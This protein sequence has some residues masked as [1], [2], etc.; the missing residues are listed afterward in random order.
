MVAIFTG[1][2]T[3][4]ERGS[5]SVLGGSGLL[6]SA[7][8]GRGGEQLF[9][10]AASGNLVIRHRD[11]FL[12]GRGG[13]VDVTRTYNSLG[14]LS[15]ENG[16]NWRQSTDRRIF[17]FTGTL[18]AWGSSVKRRSADGSEISYSWNGSAYVTTDGSGAFDTL[19]HDAG[20]NWTWTDGSSRAVEVYGFDNG[21][22]R[23]V[24]ERDTSGNTI[25][26]SYT[27]DHLT[28][29]AT[30]NGESIEYSWSGNNITGMVTSYIDLPSNTARTLTRTRYAYDGYGR[31]AT[32]TVDLTPE[33]NSVGNGEV[34]TT[35]YTYHGT[36][37]LVASISETDGSR[38]DIGYDGALRVTSITQAVASGVS[39]ITSFGYYDG[40]TTITDPAGQVT[41]L[42]FVKGDT[43]LE[44]DAWPSGNVVKEPATID[45]RAAVKYT[46]SS[47]GAWSGVVQGLAAAAGE[48]ISFALTLQASGSI[49]TQDLGLYGD[50]DQWGQNDVSFARIVS[51]PGQIQQMTGGL[52]RIS[53]LSLTQGTRIEITRTFKQ[54]QSG[55][56]Y[57]YV[58]NP[59]GY[60][61]G[62]SL[63]A[64]DP[65]LL[66]ST[67]ATSAAQMNLANWG[68]YGGA[69]RQSVG[70]IDGSPAYQISNPQGGWSG[71]TTSLTASAGDSYSF[72]LSLK[73]SGGYASQSIGLWGDG[74]HWGGND[75][76]SARIVS[77]PGTITQVAGGLFTVSG[78]SDTQVTRIEIVR[79][80]TQTENGGAYIYID[81]PGNYRAG[82]S[83]IAA[84]PLLTKRLVEPATAGQLLKITA[85][86]AQSGAAQQMVQF[87][88]DSQGNLVSVTDAAGQSTSYVYD[89]S[90]NV[91]TE[92]DRLGNIVTRTY[93]AANQILT[94][95]RTGSDKDLDAAA[96]TTHY[97]YDGSN[98]LVYVVSPEGRVTRNWYDSVG[99]LYWICD[100]PDYL[101]DLN[102]MVAGQSPSQAQLDAW[103]TSLPES[104][105]AEIT[106]IVYDARGNVSRQLR[107]SQ[108]YGY[109]HL[110]LEGDY[111]DQRFT[112]DAGGQLISRYVVG[113][114]TES[115][116]YDGLGRVVASTDL[117]GGTTNVVFADAA[118]Q[119]MVRL[120][121]G[122]VQT[123]TYNKAGELI[124]FTEAGANT[125]VG[126]AQY[127]YDRNGHLRRMIDASGVRSYFLYDKVGRKIAD[128]NEAGWITE[129]RYD[130]ND[131]LVATARY[132]NG[133]VSPAALFTYLVDPNSDI[134]LAAYRPV[135]HSFDI[136]TWTVY[137]KDGRAIEAINGDGSVAAY[138]YD[139]SGRLVR[140]VRYANKLSAAQVE[141]FKTVAPA[142]LLLPGADARDS[143]SRN[144]Y[145]KDGNLIG[146]LDGEGYLSRIVYD[147]AG[148]KVQELTWASPTN[149]ALR[150]NG[151]FQALIGSVGSD[152]RT[153]R[154]VYDGQGLLRFQIDSLFQV[155]EFG[156]GSGANAHGLVRQTIH[157]AASIPALSGYTY[158]AVKNAVASFAGNADNRLS[159]AVYDT[160]GRLA[161]SI[162]AAGGVIGYGYD[163]RGQV[164]RET[165]YANLRWT[166]SL[167]DKAAM[168]AWAAAYPSADDRTT[169]YFYN[170]RGEL[171][172]TVDADGYAT[173]ADYDAE[174]RKTWEGRWN[175]RVPV[176]DNLTFQ[177][178]K[179]L[180]DGWTDYTSRAWYYDPTGRL[181][182]E[183]NGEGERRDYVYWATGELARETVGVGTPDASHTLYVYDAAGHV[184]ARYDGYEGD[185][186]YALTTFTYDG[187]GNLVSTIDAN[188]HTTSWTW[189]RLGRKLSQT[190][191]AGG[192]ASFEYNAFGDLVRSTDARG[193]ATWNYYDRL[194]R[195]VI[196]RDAEDY[197]TETGYTVFGEVASV[198]RRASRATNAAGVGTWPVFAA[199]GA[200]AVT[201]FGYD[202]LG[203]VTTTT[204]AEGSV[205]TTW[206]DAFG[207]V[208]QARNKLGGVTVFR[209][210]RRGLVYY[211]WAVGEA[212]YDGAGN[213]VASGFYKN[214]YEYDARGNVVHQIEAYNLAERRDTW[215]SYD[216]AGRLIE[217]RGTAVGVID[218]S[219]HIGLGSTDL[220]ARYRY[221][222]RGNLI[223]TSDANGARTLFWYDELDRKVAELSPVGTLSTYGYDGVG[224]LTVSRTYGTQIALPASPGGAPPA[225]PG[226]EYRETGY[227]YDA[228]NR[229]T[230][231]SVA[232]I[233]TGAWNGTSFVLST[234]AITASYGYDAAGNVVSTTDANGVT[235]YAYYDRLGRKTA[236]VE[237]AGY[238][239][240][241]TLDS[242]G[243]VLLER[244]Y[245]T[246]T[247]GATASVQPTMQPADYD[248]ITGF[249]Y[250][251]MGR[252][253]AEHRYSVEAYAV[254]ASN[255]V[256]TGN[257]GASSVYY[258]YNGLGQVT[259]KTE[260]TGEY[261]SYG[262]DAFGRMAW[263]QR[264][265]VTDYT[266]ATGS[267][268]VGY[269][270][271]GLGNLVRSNQSSGGN[272]PD[273]VTTYYYGARGRLFSTI[274]AGGAL[275][276]FYYDAAGNV[277]R[278][279]YVRTRSDGS[280]AY[281]GILTT[282]D[283]LGRVTSQTVAVLSGS[284]WVKG[285]VQNVAYNAFGEVAQKGL[286]GGWQEQFAYDGAGRLYRS[287]S[288]DGVWRYYIHDAAGNQSA[289][290]ESEGNAIAGLSLDQ[291]LSSAT[292]GFAY[293]LGQLT[294]DGLN[295]TITGYDQRGQATSTR[296]ARR[297][298][299]GSGGIVDLVTSRSYNAFGEVITETDARGYQTSY[300]YNAMGRT[301]YVTRTPVLITRED[302]SQFL[303][304][305]TEHFYY[306]RSGRLVAHDDAN[307]NRTTRTLLAGTGYGDS[308]ALV[309]WEWHAD[310]GIVKNGYDRF[311]DLR[312]T[313]DEINRTTSMAYDAM[314]RLTQVIR[315]GGL[316][317]YYAYD[318]LGQRIRHWNSFYGTANVERT[319]YDAQGRVVSTRA[320]GGDTTTISYSWSS[321]LA[322]SGMGT[323]GGWVETTT[324]ANGLSGT[325]Y[326][327]MFGRVT[328]KSDLGG[329]TT[330]TTYDLAG[331]MTGR[332][333]S[334]AQGTEAAS[335]V[336][337]NNGQVGTL[338]TAAGGITT[339]QSSGYDA[340]GNK[341]TE[342]TTRNGA[343]IQNATATYD[344]LN[345]LL[346][347]SE[348]G[349]TTLPA[350]SMTYSY[351]A[352][353]NIR[354]MQ[355]SF[356]YLDSQGAVYNFTATQD[357][358]Y[359]Y[360]SMNRMVTSQ[361]ALSGG[362][363][364]GGTQIT[365]DAAG[366]RVSVATLSNGLVWTGWKGTYKT[367]PN[368]IVFSD[369]PGDLQE[370]GYVWTSNGRSTYSGTAVES[371]TY[372]LDGQLDTVSVA[373]E[374]VTVDWGQFNL[375]GV[376]G[377][378]VLRANF[379]YDG[380]G[381]L[382]SQ[383]DYEN[384][385][386]VA[387][388]RSNIVYDDAG[389]VTS[390]TVAA[391]QALTAVS[392][393]FTTTTTYTTYGYG[394][395]TGTGYA[396][397]AVVT[398]DADTWQGGSDSAVPDTRTTYGYSWY[399][400][401]VQSSILYRPDMASSTTNS[402]SFTL[403]P[404]GQVSGASIADGRSR[405]VTFTLD[406][407]GQAV[408]RDEADNLA[409][410][411]PHQL[412]Y[413]F[414][415]RQMGT[416]G[417]DTLEDGDYAGSIAARQIKQGTGPFRNGQDYGGGF[418]RFGEA[419]VP[420]T[421]YAQ[422]AG[423]GSY[424]AEGGETLSQ[425]A[426]QMWGDASLWYLLAEAN[427][428]GGDASLVQGQ[429]ITIPTGVTRNSNTAT[430]FKP[431]DPAETLG[432]LNP[433]T[434]KPQARKNKC[435]TFGAIVL[436]AVAIGLSAWLGPQ[437][438]QA[439]Q[440]LLAGS[441]SALAGS[442]AAI[443]GGVLGGAATGVVSS[444]ASQGFGLATGL[445][446]GGFNWGA[447]AMAGIAGGI[448]GGF[449]GLSQG[450]N[451]AG[452]V[453][454]S[455]KQL[456]GI[457]GFLSRGG[458]TSGA[459]R[460]IVSSAVT[461]G[462]GVA[463]R[464]QS[465]F[466]F[467]GIAAAGTGGGLSAVVGGSGFGGKMLNASA[468]G[469]ASAATRSALTGT[470]FGDNI[471]AV[472][473]DVIG[474]TIGSLVAERV[475]R[476][477]ETSFE[478]RRREGWGPELAQNV[479]DPNVRSDVP[480][481]LTFAP[482]DDGK[483]HK[484]TVAY[485]GDSITVTGQR[486]RGF[487]D[488][489][490][491]WIGT[492]LG[493]HNPHNPS[494]RERAYEA[495]LVI[496][497]SAGPKYAN[498]DPGSYFFAPD[499]PVTGRFTLQSRMF[500]LRVGDKVG[501]LFNSNF[502]AGSA[503]DRYVVT[504]GSRALSTT[505]KH[506]F[507]PGTPYD[508]GIVKPFYGALELIAKTP[509]G[510]PGTIATLESN[511][512]TR[513]VGAF[514]TGVRELVALRGA[515]TA[516][517]GTANP[518]A[519]VLEYGPRGEEIAYRTMSEA[520][521][522]HLQQ[523]GTLL[524]TTET[525]T[526]PL[527]SYAAKYEG[528]TVRMTTA[529]GTSGRLQEVGIAA[530]RPAAA[531]FP[532]MSTQTG[533]WM[534]TNARFKVEGGQMTTQLGQGSALN[535]FNQGLIGFQRVPK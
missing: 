474:A 370:D 382:T 169:R 99:Q 276:E 451:A 16:D 1:S 513:P 375:T 338:T 388:S 505:Y 10:N 498:D 368:I 184:I 164:I 198:T 423:G 398:I 116:V 437:F 167:P 35:S 396:L 4:L 336:W 173:R 515:V 12:T 216:K 2:G 160:A 521:F 392:N 412:W 137:D 33:D 251:R 176:D 144:F 410:G 19:V 334:G 310:G 226:G 268:V 482:N 427:G 345:R 132:A 350:A 28:R 480:S 271:D 360:D 128:I 178:V 450:V 223:E 419:Y 85:P 265:A 456:G 365:Y 95:T 428:M 290:I 414:N 346:T 297:E 488:L 197:I 239:T 489:I 448:G 207:D 495:N 469:L 47:G 504:P 445:Q 458:F 277:V 357:Y 393:S 256:L 376:M 288:G 58:D 294:V 24:S 79:N 248:R 312:T 220:I 86:A 59:G 267:P 238:A 51:G 511:G 341:L 224:N 93:N 403:T 496:R 514:A 520:H 187:L 330:S 383:T 37:K 14:N 60:R 266:G 275:T 374:G 326:S 96:H 523:T 478:R 15:D 97:V 25:T 430:T 379:D 74:S 43:A 258:L 202:K 351:D 100:F 397:G 98:R 124:A 391:R 48:T 23:I 172:Y 281:E 526:S 3:G 324:Y 409:L 89:A 465:K 52:W 418:A 385:T 195:V 285:D 112:Y 149:I 157:Y 416:V 120:V 199:S 88:Y 135:A 29:I 181:T 484:A 259:R 472:L 141:S 151:S 200:D 364:S 399:D 203:R 371:Y 426:A 182:A 264:A 421:S 211:E 279:N 56:A 452:E 231:T 339:V 387:Y 115:F 425:L 461:Q 17:D 335:Y 219:N 174:G 405:S 189:D 18:N 186:E 119:T 228:I 193:N 196:T 316:V 208:V 355:S 243:N 162:D 443:G 150:A 525:S 106:Q 91:I 481:G 9:L 308:E 317:E 121:N 280:T 354:R 139:A 175:P 68:A 435:G 479:P 44:L 66:R 13:D 289:V 343:V 292:A 101:Y 444:V 328:W 170:A 103:C 300:R 533:R 386:T 510:D 424:S 502:G 38:V 183:Y 237:A 212:V 217:T 447:V 191:A 446:Q 40:Y 535:I 286:N 420:Y 136:W 508:T 54:A 522:E 194:G 463:T 147:G 460:G 62:A 161:W 109:A 155:T 436:A 222:E 31:L 348:A 73:A 311:G 140:T 165:R 92:T 331:R 57:F 221:D 340:V 389:R 81:Y 72:S 323:F 192:I 32:V 476:A 359:R 75:A 527:L 431:F 358:W 63:I 422:G 127:L 441:G 528:I 298:L 503:A 320:F 497:A 110:N 236:A 305:P 206:Y 114:N 296:L 429:T 27:G 20:N 244:R 529:P 166:G 486:H 449:A 34:Y 367:N 459:A 282:R 263:E 361:G 159:F 327:D 84:A 154:Y 394:V 254:N 123:S 61:A 344:A 153:M 6:G 325:E 235:S 473:P 105:S 71:V 395:G 218:Q 487:L 158:A 295:V 214:L 301:L 125:T 225:A 210:D 322:T 233:R 78:L 257:G 41:R 240:A 512:L 332:T 143:V 11:E 7:T 107:G 402:T 471:V 304:Y 262:Y 5:G 45:G 373:A 509:L 108:N 408:R 83:I 524:A 532:D 117:N 464:L 462:I 53:G 319:D 321:S 400:G 337:L 507:G 204:D 477:N 274:D 55:G 261:T 401:A 145:D 273:R 291:A 517:K 90:G 227:T 411:D 126:E 384:A 249:E 21:S 313:T 64:A 272:G 470:G 152:A 133:S 501:G 146:V 122:F 230:S 366:Q 82:S 138:E 492:N 369:M 493:G 76:A 242:E 333:T 309:S 455:T 180:T 518:L 42:D 94:E 67:A 171:R 380:L 454:K 329:H 80:Y 306:D 205:E 253:T 270:Y 378:P 468:N 104:A 314:G 485:D 467:A 318:L 241:W 179:N 213:L 534:Q 404:S 342:V 500:F 440:G 70:N 209:R 307:G 363:I 131:R 113:Q 516:A 293:G 229:L 490:D 130:A 433:T 372:T 156:Y 177:V 49:T 519:P 8:L 185:P 315:P 356:R 246:R 417:N 250:D 46:V 284:A 406:A 50:I 407:Y 168:D 531:Q 457:G 302:G 269:Y 349:N 483:E 494:A 188:N 413:R 466:D 134:E 234:A 163:N 278:Q 530:N 77:G 129:Y 69:T 347:W 65:M 142:T 362:V 260:A 439:A 111:S 432:N 415:G 283:V 475:A 303:D 434:P 36:S 299:G 247:S 438:I 190:D 39:R 352:N 201:Q 118:M 453:V 390:E 245:V 232:G 255:G 381:R 26:Y 442:A 148:R 102:G 353:S 499:H 215:F 22:W 87:G 506:T 252:R 30:A 491:S 377:A 287:N